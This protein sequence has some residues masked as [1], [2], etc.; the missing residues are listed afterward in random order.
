MRAIGLTCGVGSLLI[1]AKSADF[2]IV[3][4]VE[5]RSYYHTGT[6]EANFPGAFMVRKL[7]DLSLD[8]K[9]NLAGIDLA[10]GHP[11]CGSYSCLNTRPG[12]ECDPGDIPLFVE[13]VQKLSPR[14]FVMDNM[15]RSLI[16]YPIQAWAESLP[17]YDLFPEWVS[18]YNYGNVQRWR[19]RF[20]MIGALKSEQF[21]FRPG[22]TENKKT[23][24]DALRSIR[25]NDP[26]HVCVDPSADSGRK[27][28][29]G[30][31]LSHADVARWFLHPELVRR[32]ID[33]R[34]LQFSDD[35]SERMTRPTARPWNMPYVG[36]DGKIRRRIGMCKLHPDDGAYLLTGSG[37]ILHPTTGL[38]LTCRERAR[39]QG[40][41]DDFV[42]V[43]SDMLGSKMAKQTGKF[44]PVEFAIYVAKQIAAHIQGTEFAATGRRLIGPNKYVSEAKAWYCKNKGYE[45]GEAVCKEC[46]MSEGRCPAKEAKKTPEQARQMSA[47][48]VVPKPPMV[49]PGQKR[50]SKAVAIDVDE[51][52]NLRPEAA[53]PDDYVGASKYAAKYWGQ[54]IRPDGTY[55]SR[56]DRRAYC[57][58]IEKNIQP[59][60]RSI[61]HDGRSSRLQKSGTGSWIQQWAPERQQW[62][63]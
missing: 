24:T 52:V 25:E 32:E 46:W 15:P 17:E 58:P 42:F 2:E 63:H 39:I 33:S 10:M 51:I 49:N 59:R 55:Y 45:H 62:R 53:L 21:V 9:R 6:F 36:K 48:Q 26:C 12:S 30:E 40:C 14:F 23:S 19:N 18:N 8:Q 44:M 28:L 38:P 16:G 11:D 5:W 13:M 4:N 1:G 60:L 41:P 50:R 47:E 35:Q 56:L 57:D 31:P 61:W 27:G 3:G 43:L 7:D 20:F 22:E 37:C 29:G 54:L 34:R